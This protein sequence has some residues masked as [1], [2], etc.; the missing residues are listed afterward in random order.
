MKKVTLLIVFMENEMKV[1]LKKTSTGV[2][3]AVSATEGLIRAVP[4]HFLD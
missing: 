4:C 1:G 2:V 3:L